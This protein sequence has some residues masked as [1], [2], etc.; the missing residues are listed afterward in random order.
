MKSRGVIE[1][2]E[3]QE[4]AISLP[5]IHYEGFF[6]AML[7][8]VMNEHE[9]EFDRVA[10]SEAMSGSVKIRWFS[11]GNELELR[12]TEFQSRHGMLYHIGIDGPE[13]KS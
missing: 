1:I 9:L 4:I 10:R 6:I 3:Y 11:R 12:W 8:E 13:E 2:G 7:R 5:A